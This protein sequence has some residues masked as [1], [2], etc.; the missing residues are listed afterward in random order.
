M[1]E[2]K[3]ARIPLAD[4]PW[5][6]WYGGMMWKRRRLAQLRREPFCRMCGWWADTVDHVTPHRGDLEEF[7][8]GALQSLCRT[9]HESKKKT[10]EN[11]GFRP[12]VGEDGWPTDP[13]HPFVREEPAY[14]SRK[15]KEYSSEFDV[16]DEEF[17]NDFKEFLATTKEL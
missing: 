5:R 1:S 10:E 11:R 12:G 9:C 4:Q 17:D 3:R 14:V 13:R 16:E 6:R 15:P 7:Q 8:K 2:F